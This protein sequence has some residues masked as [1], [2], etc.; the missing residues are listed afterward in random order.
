MPGTDFVQELNRR[1][2]QVYAA[3]L[4]RSRTTGPGIVLSKAAAMADLESARR[5]RSEP[6]E[7]RRTCKSVLAFCQLFLNIA[8]N[9]PS[10][11]RQRRHIRNLTGELEGASVTEKMGAS[12]A[13]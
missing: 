13:A 2:N 10:D 5:G 11:C 3:R 12:P 8:Q 7:S 4:G 9:G 6:P 1:F